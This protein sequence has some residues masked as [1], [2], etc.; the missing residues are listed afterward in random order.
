MN[1]VITILL[2]VILPLSLSAQE[3]WHIAWLRPA[4]VQIGGTPMNVGDEFKDRSAV[5][6][7]SE[8]QVMK[9]LGTDTHRC[10]VLSARTLPEQKGRRIRDYIDVCE[11]LSTRSVAYRAEVQNGV[12][13][14]FLGYEKDGERKTVVPFEGM[15]MDEM[16]Y[17]IWL[18]CMNRQ[19]GVI[20]VE[21][22]D[23]RAFVDDLIVTDD[24][25]RRLMAE[26]GYDEESYLSL[27][28]QFLDEKHR[29]I[30]LTLDEINIYLTL[31]Y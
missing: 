29:G 7:S 13:L 15:F 25:V 24:M 5:E 27:L 1:R 6:W 14:H 8:N 2:S 26:M 18:C 21:A 31:K 12:S 20:K 30:P 4:P 28:S 3:S 11:K 16:P 19:T 10:L 22:K 9:I 17:E 23:F